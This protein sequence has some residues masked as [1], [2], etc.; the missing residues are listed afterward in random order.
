MASVLRAS[1]GSRGSSGLRVSKVSKVSQSFQGVPR[2]PGVP[3]L[4]RRFLQGTRDCREHGS[5]GVLTF[6]RFVLVFQF[7]TFRV[8]DVLGCFDILPF[9]VWTSYN[10]RRF[11][12]SPF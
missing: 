5:E 6:W 12:V 8:L 9:Q 3:A 1:K 4:P 2:V 10:G 7:W 11:D